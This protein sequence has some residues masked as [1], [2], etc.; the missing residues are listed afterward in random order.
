MRLDISLY[1]NELKKSTQLC[2]LLPEGVQDAPCKVLWLLHGLTDDHTAWTRYTAIERYARDRR[3]AVVM[4]NADRSWYTNTAYGANY[5][6]FITRE[7]PVLCRRHLRGLSEARE[8]NVIAGLSMGGYGALKMALSCPEQYGA[9]ISLSGALDITR[10]GRPCDIAEWGSLFGYEL[11]S[12]DDLGGSE[13]DLFTLATQAK[14]KGLSLPRIA[15][16]C[17]QS[18][19]LLRVNRDFDCHL[20]ALDV[21]HTYEESEGDHSWRWWDLHL[22][23]LLDRVLKD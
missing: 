10:K 13:H 17:G 12:P 7:L 3:L 5:F 6:N 18:D 20:T 8:D 16:W 9:C 2:V 4:P 22:P 1:S 14:D 19:S 21:P 15:M 11:T 23:R